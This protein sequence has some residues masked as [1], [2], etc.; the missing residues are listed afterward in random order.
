MGVTFLSEE[1]MSQGTAVSNQT[2]SVRHAAAGKEVGIQFLVTEAPDG[3][4]DYYIKVA[5]GQVEVALGTLEDAD[6]KM[7]STYATSARLA[8]RELSNQKAFLTGKVKFS[9]NIAAVMR[10]GPILELIQDALGSMDVD[11]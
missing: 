6:A 3:D 1:F 4:V 10:N 9:G 5:D 8:R 7:R 11:Y 2:E